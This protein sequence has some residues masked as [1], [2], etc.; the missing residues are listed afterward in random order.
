MEDLMQHAQNL[1]TILPTW[2]IV[3][4]CI[5]VFVGVVGQWALYEKCG[6]PGYTC[7]IPVL[8]VIT[9][10]KIVGRPAKHSYMVVVPPVIMLAS[11]LL[12]PNLWVGIAVAGVACIP[13][14]YFMIKVYVEVC[15][16]FGKKDMMS[17]VLIV[18]LNGF[19]LFNLALSQEEKYHGPLYKEGSPEPSFI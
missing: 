16:C 9:F 15:Q 13:W 5:L 4:S 14:G 11:I 6:L 3:L 1:V 7:L 18:M 10:L 12:I 8:N 2:V 17:Y 19:Y